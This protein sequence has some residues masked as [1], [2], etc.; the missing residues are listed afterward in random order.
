M[1]ADHIDQ[2]LEVLERLYREIPQE[3]RLRTMLANL[4][5]TR[6]RP[7]KRN[8]GPREQWIEQARAF[9]RQYIRQHGIVDIHIIRE[10]VPLPSSVDERATGGVLK[11]PDFIKIRDKPVRKTGGR[12]KTIGEYSLAEQHDEDEDDDYGF[13]EF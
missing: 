6:G 9:A 1:R 11:H 2:V 5:L 13:V 12:I 10:H 7:K 3:H 8:S 4:E